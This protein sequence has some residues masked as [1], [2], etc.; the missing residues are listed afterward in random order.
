V[1]H[2]IDHLHGILCR[3]HL[4]PSVQPIPVEQYRGTGTGWEYPDLPRG[5]L[6]SLAGYGAVPNSP[7]CVAAGSD[8]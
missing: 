3:D 7:P 8:W 4:P 2:E 5:E 6:L 1:T